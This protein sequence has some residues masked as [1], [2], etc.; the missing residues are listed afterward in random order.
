MTAM[1]NVK[2]ATRHQTATSQRTR[3]RCLKANSARAAPCLSPVC[4]PAIACG[5]K[6]SQHVGYCRLLM[7][8]A[9]QHAYY[10]GVVCVQS[11]HRQHAEDVCEASAHLSCTKE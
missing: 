8:L 6:L 4:L 10:V 2:T 5:K 3:V 1:T 11:M 7:L 9:F